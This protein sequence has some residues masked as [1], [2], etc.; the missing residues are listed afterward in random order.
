MAYPRRF[1]L[2][3]AMKEQA[4]KI[5]A[6]GNRPSLSRRPEKPV[7]LQTS[8]EPFWTTPVPCSE[9]LKTRAVAELTF[10][11]GCTLH[12]ILQY[13]PI[14]R[15]L[16]LRRF[17]VWPPFHFHHLT[18]THSLRR[19]VKPSKASGSKPAKSLY[20]RSLSF[21]S[22]GKERRAMVSAK[23]TIVCVAFWR[24]RR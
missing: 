13:H 19:D 4:K 16:D 15:M 1:D 18:V 24:C 21:L 12:G 9:V 23:D 7:F 17:F 22:G 11:P 6:S 2:S 20:A 8:T 14:E 5:L 3:P 10:L